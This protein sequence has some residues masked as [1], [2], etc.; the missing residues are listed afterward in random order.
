MILFSPYFCRQADCSSSLF[1]MK[2][3]TWLSVYTVKSES[4]LTGIIE[5][6]YYP[7]NQHYAELIVFSFSSSQRKGKRTK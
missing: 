5:R 2:N 6:W 4:Y 7:D 1:I 3:E